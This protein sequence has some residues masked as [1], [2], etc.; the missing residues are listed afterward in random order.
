MFVLG[1]FTLFSPVFL[2]AAQLRLGGRH[3]VFQPPLGKSFSLLQQECDLAVV[4]HV[5]MF[6]PPD[7]EF[8]DDM[9]ACKHLIA[10]YL[11]PTVYSDH[12]IPAGEVPGDEQEREAVIRAITLCEFVHVVKGVEGLAGLHYG[13]CSC[14]FFNKHHACTH[15]LASL[16]FIYHV[17]PFECALGVPRGGSSHVIPP[18]IRGR[19]EV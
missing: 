11:W 15:L 3:M 4:S 7:L 18:R 14:A 2:V 16:E 17:D 8:V 6:S 12:S 5:V 13:H 10:T 9:L 19:D 1:C